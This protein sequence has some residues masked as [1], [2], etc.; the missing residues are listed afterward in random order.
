MHEDEFIVVGWQTIIHN[1]IRPLSILPELEVKD[2]G[3]FSV[4]VLLW[5]D[6]AIE[7]IT[8]LT[9]AC[10]GRQQPAIT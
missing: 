9:Q 3:V 2:P 7:H 10:N 8:M 6:D 4:K 5:R 1:D